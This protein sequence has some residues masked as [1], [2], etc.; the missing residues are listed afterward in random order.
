MN[1]IILLGILS[2]DLSKIHD[3]GVGC[4]FFPISVL[5]AFSKALKELGHHSYMPPKEGI[6]PDCYRVHDT[7]PD[8][9]MPPSDSDVWSGLRTTDYRLLDV[10][11]GSIAFKHGLC[12]PLTKCLASFCQGDSLSSEKL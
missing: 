5:Y 10:H 11:N 7:G 4:F 6:W 2:L 8:M 12:P 1:F 9:L 3:S